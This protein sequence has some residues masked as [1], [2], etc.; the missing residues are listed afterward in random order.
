MN[1]DGF[2][3]K[4]PGDEEAT[5][6]RWS[7]SDGG[8]DL[9]LIDRF[10]GLPVHEFF[11]VIEDSFDRGRGPILLALLATSIRAKFPEWTPERITRTV[12][13]LS[14]SE[15][16]FIDAEENEPGPPAEGGPAQEQNSSSSS[17]SAE[18]KPSAI[19]PANTAS[20]TS[21]GTPA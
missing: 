11:A 14:L 21:A 17:L 4:L 8:K 20:V 9:L 6:F 10:T 5:F 13:N 18:S 7:V 3:Y 15:V 1:E 19:P 2:E 16:T 12:Q